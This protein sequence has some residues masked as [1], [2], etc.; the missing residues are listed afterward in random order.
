MPAKG[1][2]KAFTELPACCKNKNTMKKGSL[3]ASI[4]LVCTTIF[5]QKTEFVIYSFDKQLPGEIQIYTGKKYIGTTDIRGYLPLG[6]EKVWFTDI[7]LFRDSVHLDYE[8]QDTT[9]LVGAYK[10]KIYEITI[11]PHKIEAILV[12]ATRIGENNAMVKSEISREELLAQNSGRDVPILLQLQPSVVTTSDAGNGVGYT[13]I[14]VR[15]S[16]ASRTNITVNGVPINDAESQGT[17][18]VNMPDLASSAG[19]VQLQRGVGSSTNGAGAFGATVNIQ[20]FSSNKPYGMLN[21]ALGSFGTRKTTIAAG[22]G[23]INSHWSADMRLSKINSNGYIDRASSDLSS[24]LFSVGYTSTKWSLKFLNFAGTEKTYQAWYGIPVEKIKGDTADLNQ[25]YARNDV[26]NYGFIYRNVSDSLNLFKSGN[27]TYNYYT[28]Q[29]E[30]DNYKQA[31]YHAYFNYNISAQSKINVTLY[32]THGE[33]YFEQFRPNDEVVKYNI[34]PINFGTDT[35]RNSDIIRQR[36]L[37]NNLVGLNANYQ[38]ERGG[39]NLITGG[40]FSAYT[41]DHFGQIVWARTAPNANYNQHYYD[42]TGDK[43]DANVFVKVTK[44]MARNLYANGDMQWRRVHH[45]G[46]GKDND[47][48]PINFNRTYHFWNP[49]IGITWNYTY[50]SQLFFSASVANHEPARSD[51]TDRKS[52]VYVKPESMVDYELGWK[53]YSNIYALEANLYF[54][55]YQDQLVLTGAVN[56]VGTSL[57]TNVKKSYRAGIELVGR[58][59]MGKHFHFIGNL[60]LSDNRIKNI[61]AISVNYINNTDS[62]RP[63]KNV[64]ISYSPA[65][66]SAFTVQYTFLKG[67]MVSWVQKYISRQYLDNTGDKTRSINA[68]YFSELWLNKTWKLKSGLQ[69]D[70]QFQILNLFNALY[71]NNGYTYDYIVG[72]QAAPKRVQEVYLFPSAT[73]NVMASLSLKF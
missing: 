8:I 38:L 44:K 30:T 32:K 31:H 52:N 27:R 28:Y 21:N 5:A 69:L 56:D 61:Q 29:N 15:G 54:M 2:V 17:F 23:L 34:Q 39:F 49:K 22:T 19:S 59:K 10:G 62:V 45:E 14:R 60:T 12:Q 4:L 53:K 71:N 66:V 18:W 47:R 6:K 41:G 63:M 72:T 51:Y 55:D 24:Y 33:G 35:L 13:G 67:Y 9:N 58:L 43:N 57:R 64:P 65:V 3:F 36:W 48:R 37:I 68:Y 42:A 11:Y 50:G 26:R 16:D 46:G 7:Q 73:R 70:A 25:Q 40:G 20:T 1:N